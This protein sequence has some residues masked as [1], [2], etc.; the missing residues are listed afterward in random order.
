MKTRNETYHIYYD[1]TA[2]WV[3]MQWH[4]YA[5]SEQFREGTELMLE[6]LKKHRASK[7]LGDIRDM[8]MMGMADQHW[9][10]NAFLPRAIAGGFRALA[11]IKPVHYFNK[12]AVETVSYKVDKDKLAINFFDS[13]EEAEQWLK[14]K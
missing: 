8:E 10:D 1:E 11:I 13:R 12:V 6:L 3:V 14:N 5:T 4:G 9:L 2:G 7:V